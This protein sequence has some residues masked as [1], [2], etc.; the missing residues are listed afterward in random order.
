MFDTVFGMIAG[1]RCSLAVSRNLTMPPFAA[2][3][4]QGKPTMTMITPQR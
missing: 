1:M 3:Y 2:L 4:P